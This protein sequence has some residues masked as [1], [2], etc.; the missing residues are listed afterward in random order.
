MSLNEANTL[1]VR[2]EAGEMNDYSNFSALP[3]PGAK[4]SFWIGRNLHHCVFSVTA[5]VITDISEMHNNKITES[6]R[7]EVTSGGF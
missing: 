2:K 1:H 6:L 3:T 4:E 7:S 5:L